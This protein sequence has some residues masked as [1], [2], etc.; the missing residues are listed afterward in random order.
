MSRAF[1]SGEGEL[2][3]EFIHGKGPE[4]SPEINPFLSMSHGYVK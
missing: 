4:I 1:Q 3:L 2:A